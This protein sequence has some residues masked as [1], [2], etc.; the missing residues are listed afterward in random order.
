MAVLASE[1]TGGITAEEKSSRIVPRMR[2]GRWLVV[3]I[4]VL[5]LGIRIGAV[6]QNSPYSP[7][8][9]ALSFDHIASALVNG[10]GFGYAETPPFTPAEHQPTA[11]RDPVYPLTLAAVY[12]VFGDHSW[13]A[14]RIVNAI[15]DTFVVLMIGVIAAQ[16]WSRRIALVALLIAAVDPSLILVGTSLQLEPLLLLLSLGSLAATLQYRRSRNDWRWAAGSGLLLG[17]A[18]LTRETA[19]VLLLPEAWLVWSA[20]RGKVEDRSGGAIRGLLFTRQAVAAPVLL[21]VLAVAPMVPWTIRNAVTMHAFIPTTTSAGIGLAGTF[22]DTVFADHVNQGEWIPPWNDQKDGQILLDM[23]NPTEVKVDS[24]YRHASLT[25]IEDHPT[26]PFRVAFWNT[27]RLFGLDRGH[28]SI[29]LAQFAPTSRTLTR[30]AIYV[31]YVLF[32]LAAIGFLCF[33]RA[34]QVPWAIW[35]IPL[36]A[37]LFIVFLLPA[38]IRYESFIE[39]YIVLLAAFPV[40][41]V[42]SFIVSSWSESRGDAAALPSPP[43]P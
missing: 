12:A 9:D 16:L 22:N 29:Y 19:A 2:A 42:A 13:T 27:E 40:A 43:Q 34:R 6:Y 10:H 25:V 5:A 30:I 8:T 23:K 33:R 7:Q 39:P 15:I 28:Y 41:W 20:H 38:Y 11:L 17:L 4:L 32:L 37:F 18:I 31:D 21:V 36:L 35:V 24:V 1:T 14:G 3:A 26:Y